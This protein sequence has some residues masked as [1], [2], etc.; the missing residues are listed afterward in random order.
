M[1]NFRTKLVTDTIIS[2][3]GINIAYI[4]SYVLFIFLIKLDKNL[5]NEYTFTTSIF[6]LAIVPSNVL[7]RIFTIEGSSLLAYL[8]K[9][10]KS[11]KFLIG[12]FLISIIAFVS[13]YLLAGLKYGIVTTLIFFLI[14]PIT[15]V[16]GILR[17]INQ[18]LGN[19][20]NTMFSVLIEASART[21]FGLVLGYALDLGIN[22]ILGSIII[23]YFL[24]AVISYININRKDRKEK[25]TQLKIESLKS[26]II[27]GI[28]FGIV[29]EV[30][31]NFDI[32]F[33]NYF[34]SKDNATLTELNTLQFFRKT[35]FFAVF[36][37]NGVA[38]YLAS[39]SKYS[40]KLSLGFSFLVSLVLS[41]F[42]A[43]GF[44]LFR[45]LILNFLGSSTKEV[46]N[47]LFLLFLL[48]SA[49]IT[50]NFIIATWIFANS[51]IKFTYFVL[52]VCLVQMAL[53]IVLTTSIESFI[54]IFLLTNLALFLSVSVISFSISEVI[55]LK[56]IKLFF[57]K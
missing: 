42:M 45:D 32:L 17:G 6:M 7:L 52:A 20:T 36:A 19:F 11:S 51:N 8:G 10:V 31:A 25:L 43:C 2:F 49:L 35:I 18:N 54:Y 5:F 44:Y 9:Q 14:V 24:A 28:V 30:F 23:G 41:V 37:T 38:L 16:T 56:A 46:S 33:S 47:I 22:G 53:F 40:K 57:T 55:K 29:L 13:F 15:L 1:S 21:G 27:S 39:N 12:I 26:K 50:T 3:V 48:G 4:V 34:F